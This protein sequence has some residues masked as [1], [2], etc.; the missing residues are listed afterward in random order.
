MSQK[1]NVE[2]KS[3]YY[4][5]LSLNVALY[6][7]WGKDMKKFYIIVGIPLCMWTLVLAFE[8]KSINYMFLSLLLA[9]PKAPFIFND[10]VSELFDVFE[11]D[12]KESLGDAIESDRLAS[13]SDL[14]NKHYEETT[15]VVK[16]DCTVT[17]ITQPLSS[18][19]LTVEPENS[20]L[21]IV[22]N[23]S[24]VNKRL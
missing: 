13:E 1:S 17:D 10:L 14:L 19:V 22:R 4:F 9:I 16:H 11:K 3:I 6:T 8:N 18:M 24:E 21:L 2:I 12:M 20:N 23:V 15:L 5:F 7:N